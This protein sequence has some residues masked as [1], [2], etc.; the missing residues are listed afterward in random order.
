MRLRCSF[1]R[2]NS[3]AIC[4]GERLLMSNAV[5]SFAGCLTAPL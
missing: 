2:A 4:S 3:S 5:K 1:Q